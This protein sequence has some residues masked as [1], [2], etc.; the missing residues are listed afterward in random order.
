MS[1]GL[2][3]QRAWGDRAVLALAWALMTLCGGLAA[4]L[5]E[6]WLLFGALAMALAGGGSVLLFAAQDKG[7]GRIALSVALMGE[8]SLVVAE[9]AGRAWQFD[10][11]I[12]YFVVLALLAVYCDWRVIVAGAATAAAH[13]LLLGVMLPALV[14][15]GGAEPGRLALHAGVLLVEAAALILVT[16][17]LDARFSAMAEGA[18]EAAE[19]QAA[20]EAALAAAEAAHARTRGAALERERAREDGRREQ[21]RVVD[22]LAEGLRRLSGGDLTIRVTAEFPDAYR[23]LREDFNRSVGQLEAAMGE[24]AANVEAINGGVGEITQAADDLSRRTERQAVT[25]EQA[26]V[27]LGEITDTIKRTADGA[28]RADAALR[29]A[30]A[31]AKDT[32]VIAGETV[33]AMAEIEGS[34]RQIAQIVGTIDE[35][36]FQTNLLAL[37]AGVE[38]A[39]AGD[40]GRGFAVVAQEVRALAH[41]AASAAREIRGLIGASGQQVARGVAQVDQTGQGLSQIA[42]Q[43]EAIVGMV[44]GIAQAAGEQSA[45]L[46]RVNTT[47]ERIGQAKQRNMAVIDL[48]TAAAQLIADEAD[49]LADLAA[50]FRVGAEPATAAAAYERTRKAG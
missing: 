3:I 38:A 23:G 4:L 43:V 46:A 49:R 37:N 10:A 19:L 7:P 14:Y 26:A 25:L 9:L 31:S 30:S 5:G 6:N 20:T 27:T 39:R 36:A 42:G 18:Q 22:A 41:R 16:A 44:A 32:G 15:P 29:Q 21:Q 50:G 47:I 17:H 24:L 48:S 13:H 12:G 33:S 11:Q 40:A 34:A 35:I 8:L 28:G 2:E 1:Q 45:G